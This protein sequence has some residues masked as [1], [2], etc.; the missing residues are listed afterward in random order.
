MLSTNN[1]S[2]NGGVIDDLNM[3]LGRKK[4]ILKWKKV[5]P[6]SVL[7][8]EGCLYGVQHRLLYAPGLGSHREIN[9]NCAQDEV[10]V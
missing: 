5:Y 3:F 7:L 9:R 2:L 10:D 8:F 6:L 4:C 1:V